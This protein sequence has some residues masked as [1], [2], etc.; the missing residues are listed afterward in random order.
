M[1]IKEHLTG[2]IELVDDLLDLVPT[3][4]TNMETGSQVAK[5]ILSSIFHRMDKKV[6]NYA[7]STKNC[8]EVE[9]LSD[10]NDDLITNGQSDDLTANGQPSVRASTPSSSPVSPT[11]TFQSPRHTF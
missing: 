6:N 11:Y 3:D 4:K 8:E 10:L 9:V 1:Y 5:S 7:I 2:D